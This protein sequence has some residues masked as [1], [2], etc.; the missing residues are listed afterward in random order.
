[1]QVR[2]KIRTD[3]QCFALLQ[4]GNSDAFY[5]L[6]R[7]YFPI[8]CE[9][10]RKMVQDAH[11]AQDITH[12][13]FIK[14]W[15]S[16]SRFTDFDAIKKFL[17]VSVKNASLNYLRSKQREKVRHETFMYYQEDNMLADTGEIIHAELMAAV[18][19][20]IEQLPDKMRRVFILSYVEQLSN[21][22]VAD[23]LQLS[24]QTV[25][26][27]KSRAL[28]ILR[29]ILKDYTV[30]QILAAAALLSDLRS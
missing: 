14:I 7:V 21:E 20:A 13:I 10:S 16:S 18:R 1:M 6:I 11:A 30:A 24:N 9:I 3:E 8:F 5:Y 23:R 27:Q 4:Q 25:R 28:L 15:E 17:Y 2:E 29:S 19:R 26:N 12:N 22:E